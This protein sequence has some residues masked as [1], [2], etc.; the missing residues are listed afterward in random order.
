MKFTKNFRSATEE[1]WYEFL[2]GFKDQGI[3][4][5]V[6]KAVIHYNLYGIKEIF[7]DSGLH[8]ERN[9]QLVY[10]LD[11]EIVNR[12]LGYTDTLMSLHL[13]KTP[14]RR[15]IALKLNP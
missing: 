12:L 13:G 5:A 2:P 3:G 15:N 14:I 9:H 10:G 6:G 1:E 4:G 8:E 11:V 7:D